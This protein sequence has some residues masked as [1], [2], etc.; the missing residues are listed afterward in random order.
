MT[1]KALVLWMSF[2]LPLLVGLA[3]VAAVFAFWGGAGGLT[4]ARL[5]T[6]G[7]SDGEAPRPLGEEEIVTLTPNAAHE[8]SLAQLGTPPG[9]A[10]AAPA[11]LLLEGGGRRADTIENQLIAVL[12]ARQAVDGRVPVD[13]AQ[14]GCA[15]SVTSAATSASPSL[16]PSAPAPAPPPPFDPRDV[17]STARAAHALLAEGYTNRSDGRE[18]RAVMAAM[19]WLRC[20]QSVDG[21]FGTEEA[22]ASAL[23]DVSAAAAFLRIEAMTGSVIWRAPRT[24]GMTALARWFEPDRAGGLRPGHPDFEEAAMVAVVACATAAVTARY[25]REKG[26]EP[27]MTPPLGLTL[28]LAAWAEEE[29]SE[30]SSGE[31]RR[32]MARRVLGAD[33][34]HDPRLRRL[35]WRLL[36]APG[37]PVVPADPLDRVAAATLLGTA[38]YEE[39]GA[40]YEA[41]WTVAGRRFTTGG[42][43][44]D[45][46]L[47]D[48]TAVELRSAALDA[49]ARAAFGYTKCYSDPAPFDVLAEARRHATVLGQNWK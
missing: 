7:S 20:H 34:K 29:S 12:L 42:S 25:E 6:D 46:R 39:W 16:A 27:T 22:P 47:A 36:D 14:W 35:V 3:G 21:S 10:V 11:K 37:G 41:F 45:M 13:P 28:G 4:T 49:D 38:R 9:P 17:I 44:C 1:R 8:T 31:L 19:R 30:G 2:G 18:G 33:P 48:G 23:A 43:A 15:T 5:S 24:L 32:A 26:I 40:W